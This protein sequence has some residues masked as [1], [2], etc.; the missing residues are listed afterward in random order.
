MDKSILDWENR[1]R[2]WAKPP[3]T[4]EQHR[5]LN[6]ESVVRNAIKRSE[7]L[8]ERNI[9]V[10]AQGSYRNNTNVPGE[11]DVDIAV[12]CD[13]VFF[14]DYPTGTDASTFGNVDADY[15]YASFKN[16]V[17][18]ALVS[19]LGRG[20]VRHGNKAFD[21]EETT[22]H[23]EADVAPFFQHRRYSEE[24]N[25]LTG[26][27]LRPDTGIPIKVINWPEQHRQKGVEKNN[28]TGRRYKALVR[29]LKSLRNEMEANN[30]AAAKP[31]PR[32]FLIECLAWNIPNEL[33]GNDLYWDDVRAALLHL[34]TATETDAGCGEWGEVSE[35]KY[36]FRSTQRWTRKQVNTFILAAWGYV[37]FQ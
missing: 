7:T 20:A 2:A 33:F 22:Y 10:F 24:G 16:A 4:T 26:I 12:V 27:E 14:P 36:L 21:I 5:M 19:Y 8:Q 28:A 31:I 11:S 23:V 30:V 34:Y 17:E 1:F 25:F 35:L 9:R 6:A 15:T 3:G 18:D 13:D 37:G 32:G 29:V